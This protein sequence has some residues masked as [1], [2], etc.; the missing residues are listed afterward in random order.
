AVPELLLIWLALV[1]WSFHNVSVIHIVLTLVLLAIM[2]AVQIRPV[3]RGWKSLFRMEGDAFAPV[4]VAST[5][6]LIHTVVQMFNTPQIASPDTAPLLLPSVAGL[7]L[8]FSAMGRQWR[9]ARIRNNFRVVSYEGE[10]VAACK[11]D[12]PEQAR[13]IGRTA[14]AMGVPEV[15]YFKKARF[16]SGY[17]RHSYTDDLADEQTRL[18]LP[19][20]LGVALLLSIPMFILSGSV[21]T[22]LSVFTAAVCIA[23]PMGLVTAIHLPLWRVSRRLVRQ[24]AMVSGWDAVEEFGGVHAITVDALDLFPEN[25]VLLHGIK[26]FSGTPIDRAII[27]AA[28]VAIQAGG[29]LAGVFKRVLEDSEKLLQPVESLMYEQDMGVSGWVGG[30][31]VLVGN[32]KLLENHGVDVPSHD[33]ELRYTQGDRRL[34]YLSTAGEL[35]AMFVVS[36]LADEEIGDAL[37]TLTG[38]GVTLLVRTCDPN[39]NEDLICKAYDLDRY[40]VEVMGASAGRL[41]VRLQNEEFADRE[42][43]I[44]SNGWLQGKA[45][46]LASCR[47]L[48]AAGRMAIITQLAGAVLG[49]ALTAFA[50][51]YNGTPFAAFHTTLYIALVTGLSWLLPRFKRV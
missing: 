10:K 39:V 12:D 22:A 1:A 32:R 35:S 44:G 18:Y 40:Y 29:P 20:S 8:L 5:V 48:K 47:R 19:V 27:D 38:E 3:L 7:G 46:A 25:S 11:I 37:E 17:L 28:S 2:M 14:V 50:V 6:T 30:R 45:L 31:R 36:Y 21:F 42:A 16:L 24:G 4:A 51:F 15:C 23:A 33:Y 41:Y 43:L 13:Q 49:L 34:V 9:V 26:T